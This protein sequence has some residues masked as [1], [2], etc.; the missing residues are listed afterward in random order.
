LIVDSVHGWAAHREGDLKKISVATGG[1]VSY[2]SSASEIPEAMKKLEDA[3]FNA[4]KVTLQASH[5]ISAGAKLKVEIDN[6]RAFYPAEV[7]GCDSAS[8]A[9]TSQ[10]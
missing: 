5:P 6:F 3:V 2:P 10:R 1:L 8:G 7:A 4:F 9:P